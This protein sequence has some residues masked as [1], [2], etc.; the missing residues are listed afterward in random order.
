MEL[1]GLNLGY[2]NCAAILTALFV[3]YRLI[4]LFALWKNTKKL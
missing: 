1:F 3:G 4:S 2:W